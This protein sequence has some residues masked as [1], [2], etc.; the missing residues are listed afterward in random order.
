VN[1][2]QSRYQVFYNIIDA[3]V[4]ATTL[5]IVILVLLA[6]RR[7]VSGLAAGGLKG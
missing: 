1:L 7:I 6:Q 2:G 4:V 5:P 3:G